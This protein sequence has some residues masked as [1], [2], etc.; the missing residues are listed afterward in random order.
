MGNKDEM[1]TEKELINLL[2]AWWEGEMWQRR[3]V[4][5]RLQDDLGLARFLIF[6]LQALVYDP[7]KQQGDRI[8]AFE[9]LSR[10]VREHKGDEAGHLQ[11]IEDML[12]KVYGLLKRY[13]GDDEVPCGKVEGKK[14]SSVMDNLPSYYGRISEVLPK[15]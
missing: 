1:G 4:L 7:G 13:E 15:K 11:R 14:L 3:A 10:C 12:G 6:E 5:E 9:I 8:I 2:R